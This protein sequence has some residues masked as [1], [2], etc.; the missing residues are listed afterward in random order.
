M[1]AP[2]YWSDAFHATRRSWRSA[3]GNR[4]LENVGAGVSTALVALPLNVALALVCGLPASVGLWTGAI[5]GVL[6]AFFG[7]ARLQVTGPEV[8]LAPLTLAIVQEHGVDGMLWCT[9][10]AGLMQ[11]GLGLARVGKL[12][13]LVPKPVVVGFMAAVGVMVL[14]S[15]LPRLLGLPG[16]VA[17]VGAMRDLAWVPE[18]SMGAAMLGALVIALLVAIPKLHRRIPAPLVAL[19]VAI[20]LALGLDVDAPRVPDI[21][22]IVST[23]GLP[24]LEIERFLA[25]LPSAIGLCLL[26]SLDSLLSAVSIDARIGDRH[27]SDQ[28]LVAQGIAN[29]ACGLL[30]GMPVAGAIV[31]SA[32][33]ADA[34]GTNRMAPL[35]QSIA[36]GVLLVVFGHHLDVIPVAALAAV[37]LVVGAKLLQP[38]ELLRIYR[39]SRGDAAVVATTVVAILA[40]DFVPG[41]VCGIVA[42]LARMAAVHAKVGVRRM[43]V[44]AASAVGAL[45]L[46]GPLHFA[47]VGSAIR[48]IEATPDAVVVLDLTGVTAIDV[49]AVEALLRAATHVQGDARQ[50]LITG[51][52]PS[53]LAALAEGGLRDALDHPDLSRSL[54]EV[55]AELAQPRRR[56]APA[57]VGVARGAGR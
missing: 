25:L 7:G 55:L 42:A 56:P 35:V 54:H 47:N 10:L 17:T 9:L 51:A 41:V 50:F 33:A 19:G 21:D 24:R 30:G 3:F 38:R 20:A 34:G 52:R 11:V 49:T 45:R 23:V 29:A 26:A 37:L 1:N 4:V 44:D 32:A 31:R 2:S 16:E 13:Q 46:E 27:R 57:L 53:V 36:L 48:A 22:G 8:A 18:I 6:G 43:P 39:R 28:E 12:V 5:A 14:D 15:Q 40:I